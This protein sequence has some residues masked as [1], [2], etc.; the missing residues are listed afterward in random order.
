MVTPPSVQT[1]KEQVCLLIVE[2]DEL[3]G[4]LSV[5]EEQSGVNRTMLDEANERMDALEDRLDKEL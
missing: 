2:I 3:K 1:L 5:V 4:R